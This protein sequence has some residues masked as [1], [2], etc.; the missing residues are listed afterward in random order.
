MLRVR[1]ELRTRAVRLAATGALFV[2]AIL[3]SS[4]PAGATFSGRDGALLVSTGGFGT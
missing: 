4:S 2:M 3:A 1:W